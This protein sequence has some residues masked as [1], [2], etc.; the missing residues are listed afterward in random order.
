MGKSEIEALF[1]FLKSIS[2]K[3]EEQNKE[4]RSLNL[5]FAVLERNFETLADKVDGMLDKCKTHE[6]DIKK[7]GDFMLIHDTKEKSI[8]GI[9]TD[10]IAWIGL[11]AALAAIAANVNKLTQ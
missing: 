11:L 1:K 7:A 10:F 8:L 9:R 3:M 4:I 5:K 6:T 2:E